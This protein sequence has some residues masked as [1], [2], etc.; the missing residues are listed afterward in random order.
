LSEIKNE[1]GDTLKVGLL[2]NGSKLTIEKDSHLSVFEYIRFNIPESYY[3]SMDDDQRKEFLGTIHRIKNS[4]QNTRVGI[5]IVVTTS[6]IRNIVDMVRTMYE[7][8]HVH[9]VKVKAVHGGGLRPSKKELDQLSDDLCGLR[10]ASRD[11]SDLVVDFPLKSPSRDHRC[12]ISPVVTVIEAEGKTF[13]CCNISDSSPRPSICLQKISYDGYEQ[14]VKVWR[15]KE[16]LKLL[17]RLDV[18]RVCNLLNAADCR[19]YD[20]QSMVK[21]LIWP[22]FPWLE[23]GN[24]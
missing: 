24:E 3:L 19:F 5:K 4:S 22:T 13:K 11:V 7:D 8:I 9:H 1:R 17:Q 20:F 21:R 16:H 15:S 6:N 14:Y 10:F 12:W 2:T 23:K 18:N